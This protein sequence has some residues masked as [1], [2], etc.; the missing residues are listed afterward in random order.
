MPKKD[1]GFSDM[2]ELPELTKPAILENLKERFDG[3]CRAGRDRVG[4]VHAST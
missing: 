1:W 4:C 2:C 3:E